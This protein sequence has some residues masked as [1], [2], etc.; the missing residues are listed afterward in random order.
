MFKP[1]SHRRHPRD[2][3][4]IGLISD[5]HGRADLLANALAF[6]KRKGCDTIYHL[7]DICDSLHPETADACVG[8]LREFQVNGVKGNNDH[9]LVV[10]HDGRER[11]AIQAETIGYL[12]ALPLVIRVEGSLLAHSLPFEKELGLA[13]MVGVMSKDYARTFFQRFADRILF[14][15][16]SHSPEIVWQ[17]HHGHVVSENIPR[18]Q[19]IKTTERTPCIVTCGALDQGLCLL[20]S[21]TDNR[22]TS[23][24]F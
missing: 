10:N 5:S 19:A 12:R 17:D 21:P 15:G 3:P 20:W 6:M 16:H 4:L 7:G 22:V 8:L 13:C 1:T 23:V 11:S 24:K 2:T 18:G 14:R 9:S